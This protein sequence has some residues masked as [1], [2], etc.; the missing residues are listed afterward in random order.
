VV[1]LAGVSEPWQVLPELARVLAVEVSSQEPAIETLTQVLRFQER[2]LVLDN[3][4]HVIAAAPTLAQLAGHCSQLKLLV[5]SRAPLHVTLEQ[6]YHVN[7]LAAPDAVRN[8][9]HDSLREWPASALFI[10][11][12]RAANPGY[13]PVQSESVAIAELCRYLGGL[14]LA[15]ELAA[16]STALLSPGEILDRLRDS[17]LALGPSSRDAPDRHQTIQATIDWSLELLAED[18]QRLFER[19]GVFAGGFTI[20]AAEAVCGDLEQNV[21]AGLATL[22]DHGLIYRQ[23]SGAVSRLGMLEPVRDHAR[24][25]MNTDPERELAIRRHAEHYATL[26]EAAHAELTSG[27]QLRC[28]ARLDDEQPNIRAALDR[29]RARAEIDIALRTAHALSDYFLIRGLVA[30][31]RP[32]LAWALDQPPGDSAIRAHGLLDLGWLADEDGEYAQAASA[33][34]ECHALCEQLKNVS[35]TARCEAHIAC[36]DWY[37]GHLESSA[38]YA[39]RALA[40]AARAGDPSTEAI[41]LLVTAHS[42][43]SYHDARAKSQ[44]AL[45]ILKSLGDRIWPPRIKA[46][47]AK[48]AR[49]AGDH[50]YARL[51]IGEAMADL[52]PIW[53]AGLRAQNERELGLIELSDGRNAEAREHLARSLA[54]GRSI[55]DRRDTRDALIGLAA[56]EVAEGAPERASTLL[57]AALALLDEPLDTRATLDGC[58][59]TEAHLTEVSGVAAHATGAA[60]P[61]L[62]QLETILRN[63]SEDRQ[64]RAAD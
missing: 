25:R 21:A 9:S 39:E 42:A 31:R 12:A 54:L 29:A 24:E 33:L 50:E 6:V 2:L 60:P 64:A 52:D 4:E 19:L 61:T 44:R 38:Q 23:A 1:W 32:W 45:E 22:V 28:L 5:T 62:A 35:L 18:E 17:S 16:A 51:L 57:A 46:N 27:D 49:R 43:R 34:A 41:V 36:N 48:Q 63:A 40:T 13:E 55:G 30:E 10:D 56:L 47:L 20:E 37:L 59:L 14:P 3:F 26:A 11:R 8:A 58:R 7:G 15:L 53:G